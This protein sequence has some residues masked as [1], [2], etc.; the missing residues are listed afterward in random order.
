MKCI[1]CKNKETAV[2]NSRSTKEGTVVWRRRQCEKCKGTFTTK[3]GALVDHLFII[4]RN[5]SRQRFVYEKL[6]V[7]I[8]T[9]LG[10]GKDRDNGK[11]AMLAKIITEKVLTD[12][13]AKHTKVVSSEEVIAAVYE[14]LMRIDSHAADSYIFYSWY[15]REVINRRT[16]HVRK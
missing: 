11:Q 15:R 12:L 1:Y 10:S 14:E 7:S 13:V 3:E 5:G 2:K 6:F 8:F 4:K 9:V 16:K